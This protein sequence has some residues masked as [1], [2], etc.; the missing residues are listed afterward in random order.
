MRQLLVDTNILILWIVGTFDRDR[1]GSHRRTKTFEP[2]DF[3]LLIRF[4]SNFGVALTT[5][6]IA[7][8]TSNLLGNDFHRAAAP[9]FLTV[10]SSFVEIIKPMSAVLADNAFPRLG[11]SDVASLLAMDAR[12]TLL[13][14]DAQLYVETLSRGHAAINF[15]HMKSFEQ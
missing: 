10:C 7:S 3:D 13:T 1:V 5:P 8:E 12:T 9:A 14:D 6:S 4:R 2:S 15:S 11:F